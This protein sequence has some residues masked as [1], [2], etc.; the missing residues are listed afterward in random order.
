MKQRVLTSILTVSLFLLLTNYASVHIEPCYTAEPQSMPVGSI[1]AT[2]TSGNLIYVPNYPLLFIGDSRTVG[3]KQALTYYGY[4]LENTSFLAKVGKGYTWFAGQNE[5]MTVPPS[6][7]VLNLGV[8]DLGNLSRYQALYEAYAK[9]CWA[10][11]PI[12]IVSVNPCSYPCTSVSNTQ[13]EA[14]NTGMQQ[15]IEEFNKEN[16]SADA[17]AFPI[18]YID[19]YH[20]LLS[21]GY[22][23]RDGLHYTARTYETIYNYIMEEIQEPVGNG[24]GLYIYTGSSYGNSKH[25]YYNTDSH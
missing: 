18:R 6:I 14:F 19:T 4:D 20:Y 22:S 7:I 23:S 17:E 2:E 15:W 12:Y 1:P 3:M 8:N 10:G 25:L 24:N 13:I 9:D 16:T 5:V 11:C 21:Q